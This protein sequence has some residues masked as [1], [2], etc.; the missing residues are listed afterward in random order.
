MLSYIGIRIYNVV[1]AGVTPSALGLFLLLVSDKEGF[2]R[3]T[4]TVD[5]LAIILKQHGVGC[6]IRETF[7]SILLYA[8]DIALMSPTLRGLQSL[9]DICGEYCMAWNICQLRAKRGPLRAWMGQY[10]QGYN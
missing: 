5:E 1:S 2:C 9:L 7:R 8:D 10:E 6:F 4:F 3:R